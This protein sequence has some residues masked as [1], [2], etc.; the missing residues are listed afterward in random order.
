MSVT[1][2]ETV[3]VGYDQQAALRD[4]LRT[5]IE[6]RNHEKKRLDSLETAQTTAH[7]QLRHAESKLSD[8]SEELRKARNSE[9]SRLA[10]AFASGGKLADDPVA[11]ATATVAA[12]EAEVDQLKK[13]EAALAGEI[14]Q[15]QRSMRTL[16]HSVYQCMSDIV[17]A[18]D[19]YQLLIASQKEAFVRLRSVKLAMRQV[20]QG[21]HGYLPQRFIEEAYLTEPVSDRRIGFSVDEDLV[22]G[23]AE[24]LAKLADDADADLPLFG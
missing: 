2:T 14:D 4:K 16:T 18:S 19:E 17:V 6:R 20:H 5:A 11:K 7:R 12:S 9:R 13:V 8:A 1:D 3:D 10:Y 23:W 15:L 21:L 24:A 22:N